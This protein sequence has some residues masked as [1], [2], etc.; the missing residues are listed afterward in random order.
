[1][2]DVSAPSAQ[3]SASDTQL[4]PPAHQN[5]IPPI[6]PASSFGQVT[7]AGLG[8]S[9]NVHW[10]EKKAKEATEKAKADGPGQT[11]QKEQE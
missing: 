11:F 1:M 4:K 3:A 5:N 8:S 7:G 2:A 9:P 6:H 10:S